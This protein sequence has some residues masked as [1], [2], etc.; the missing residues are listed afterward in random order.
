MFS[1]LFHITLQLGD[2]ERKEMELQSHLERLEEQL[3]QQQQLAATPIIST[4]PTSRHVSSNSRQRV[5]PANS[6]KYGNT[7]GKLCYVVMY[8]VMIE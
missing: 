2:I 6:T 3:L 5:A 8:H 1:L 4:T 7:L